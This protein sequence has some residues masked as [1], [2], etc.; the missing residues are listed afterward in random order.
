M[1][2]VVL[3]KPMFEGEHRQTMFTSAG[4]QGGEVALK[5]LL[6]EIEVDRH[7]DV[8]AFAGVKLSRRAPTS[9]GNSFRS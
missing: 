3:I 6:P 5:P 9:P 4:G 1:S 8:V 7:D 2:K